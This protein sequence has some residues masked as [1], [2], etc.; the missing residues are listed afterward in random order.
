[1][2]RDAGLED[3]WTQLQ[4][5][6]KEENSRTKKRRK[7]KNSRTKKRRDAGNAGTLE[8][9]DAGNAGTLERRDTGNAGTLGLLDAAGLITAALSDGQLIDDSDGFG[10]AL[11]KRPAGVGVC[12]QNRLRRALGR[13]CARFGIWVLECPPNSTNLKES[14]K[15][16]A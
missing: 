4:E 14:E 3:N 2:F 5:R 15:R 13:A 16:P 10:R 9:R 12:K 8:R 6:R 7:E 11:W 1:M